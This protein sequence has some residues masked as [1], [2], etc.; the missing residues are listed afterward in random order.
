MWFQTDLRLVKPSLYAIFYIISSFI[1]HIYD[2]LL[3]SDI[4]VFLGGGGLTI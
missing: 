2:L 3:I 1:S 4:R